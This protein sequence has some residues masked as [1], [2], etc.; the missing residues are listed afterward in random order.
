MNQYQAC[1]Y[2]FECISHGDSKYGHEIPKCGHFWIFCDFVGLSSA[3]ACFKPYSDYFFS[4]FP[5][6]FKLVKGQWNYTTT[7][8]KIYQVWKMTGVRWVHSISIDIQFYKKW[9]GVPLLLFHTTACGFWTCVFLKNGPF[10][11]TMKEKKKD[12]ADFFNLL[13]MKLGEVDL[14][15]VNVIERENTHAKKRNY[16]KMQ[17]CV[18]LLKQVIL[19]QN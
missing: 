8:F 15:K 18:C 19:K 11:Y 10:T 16:E 17:I 1:L 4:V 9:I 13:N 6:F 5:F 7:E 3:L 2:L 12:I 14:V